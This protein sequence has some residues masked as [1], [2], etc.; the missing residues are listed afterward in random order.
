ML[1]QDQQFL[2]K[3]LQNMISFIKAETDKKVAQIKKET[4]SECNRGKPLYKNKKNR[5]IQN[6]RSWENENRSQIFKE[7]KRFRRSNKNVN[8][9]TLL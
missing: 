9:R 2:V 1:S 8:K 5:E 3:N 7:E 6:V 4:A